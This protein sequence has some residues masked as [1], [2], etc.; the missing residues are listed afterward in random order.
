MQSRDLVHQIDQDMNVANELAQQS[1]SAMSHVVQSMTQIKDNSDAIDTATK[2]I[3]GIAEQTNLLA[4]NAAIEA[5][6]AGEAG[7]SFA[8]VADEVRSLSQRSSKSADE[9]HDLLGRN[10]TDVEKGVSVVNQAQAHMTQMVSSVEHMVEVVST[11]AKQIENQSIQVSD[12]AK[13]GNEI[14]EISSQQAESASS[15]KASQGAL[16]SSSDRLEDL[17]QNLHGLVSS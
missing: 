9:I 11:V 10:A 14:A 5:A 4:L 6:R 15:L 16:V 1:E 13:S 7:R 17:S 3:N 8:V 12:M 2:M